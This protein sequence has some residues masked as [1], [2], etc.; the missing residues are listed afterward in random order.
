MGPGGIA[1]LTPEVA[2]MP[3]SPAQL[4]ANRRNSLLS[5]GPTSPQGKAISRRNSLKHGLTG[6][7]VVLPTD[8]EAEVARRF[9]A[10]QAELAPKSELARMLVNRV[11]TLSLR[12]EHCAEHEA[13]NAAFRMRHAVEAFDD[14]R[15]AEVEKTLS[16]IATEPATHARRL[17]ATP[18]GIDRLIDGLEGLKASL[19]HPEGVRW[20]WTYCEQVHH[21]MGRRPLE[22][23]VTRFRALSEAIEG[24]FRHLESA[25]GA[26]LSDLDRRCWAAGMLI[27]LIGEEIARLKALREGLDH[28]TIAQDRAEAPHRA[29]F[30]TSARATLLRKYEASAERGFFRALKEL[31]EVQA[32]TPEPPNPPAETEVM[33]ESGSFLPDDSEPDEPASP[34]DHIT[35]SEASSDLHFETIRP[36]M[37]A[38]PGLEAALR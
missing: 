10:L 35:R 34:P 25:D 2:P 11:A 26:G 14:Q 16:W 20:D 7:G 13:K 27:K 1:R 22:V 4:E 15:L 33:E 29:M 21:L 36:E 19:G 32:E 8:D 18:E 12:M 23:P 5:K 28:G 24:N 30:D 37:D 31:R 9:E 17:R 3:C 38:P 6:A